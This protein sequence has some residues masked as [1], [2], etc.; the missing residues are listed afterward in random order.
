MP[1]NS[2]KAGKLLLTAGLLVVL[3]QGLWEL[4]ELQDYT[5]PGYQLAADFQTAGIECR[6]IE[7]DLIALRD[8][9]NYIKWAMAQRGPYPKFSACRMFSFP[10]SEHIRAF[11]PHSF[12]RVNIYLAQKTRVREE[13]RLQYLEALLNRIDLQLQQPY[14]PDR[15]AILPRNPAA[16][17][18]AQ[19]VK[20]FQYQ[21][22]VY[23]VKLNDLIEQLT[24]VESHGYKK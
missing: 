9:V 15:A 13:R 18:A 16:P 11:S 7:A 8:R 21:C 22:S 19:Q 14:C 5:S 24:W 12:W 23:N 4:P 10:F 1:I 6:K 2:L 20:A 3:A 17:E